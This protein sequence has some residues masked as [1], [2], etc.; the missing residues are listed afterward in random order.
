MYKNNAVGNILGMLTVRLGTE[1]S[2]E[3][4][5]TVLHTAEHSSSSVL[6]DRRCLNTTG[7]TWMPVSQEKLSREMSKVLT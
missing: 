3:E 1:D 5:F 4:P 6:L 2:E 7:S